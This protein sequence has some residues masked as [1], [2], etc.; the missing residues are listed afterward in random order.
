MLADLFRRAPAVAE[1]RADSPSVALSQLQRQRGGLEYVYAPMP[2]SL[3]QAMT[4][5]AASA[6]VDVLASSV[7]TLPLD[8]VRKQG[9]TRVQVT[10]TPSLIVKPSVQS[11]VDVWLY[12]V[13][14]SMATDGNAFGLVGAVDSMARPTSIELVNPEQV[15][16]RRVV[17]G[18]P[19]A[20]VD[21]KRHEM[22]PFGDLWH[23]PGK[24]TRAGS[25]FADSPLKRALADISMALAAREYGGRFFGDGAHSTQVVKPGKQI[26]EDEARV[27]KAKVLNAVRGTREP[28][29]LGKDDDIAALDSPDDATKFL[30]LMQFAVLEACRHW[31]VPPGMVYAAVS[32]QSVTYSNVDQADLA[33][34]KFSLEL[35][36]VRIERAL[37]G[38]IAPGQFA[39]FN[40]K[41]W[42]RSDAK[43]RNDIYD[44]RLKNKTMSVNQVRALEDEPPIA[45]PVFDQPGIPSRAEGGL[46]P[47]EL[48]EAL[49]KIY[50]SVG[51]VISA[52][53]ARDI[54]NRAGA[55][56]SKVL[57][58]LTGPPKKPE[59]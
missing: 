24:F 18:V 15:T 4:Q 5:A 32:G 26:N 16:G 12:Q 30:E 51:V 54:L 37:T 3:R 55:D 6:C 57:P 22:Y 53:E 49:Q 31:R 20:L 1:E 21:G 47:V 13:V 45:D 38:L 29:V 2:V 59:A 27:W 50:L 33:F 34:L 43:T 9:S 41:A 36:L 25:P 56:L 19:E 23:V 14:D 28:L 7:A 40:R 35:Y 42:L 48:A 44:L 39:M 10:P 52:E 58:E 17:G 11:D 8:V 46:S